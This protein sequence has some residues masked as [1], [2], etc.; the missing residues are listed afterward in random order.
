MKVLPEDQLQTYLLQ[1]GVNSKEDREFII[2]KTQ[3]LP[4]AVQILLKIYQNKGGRFDQQSETEGYT[5]LFRLYFSRH[6]GSLTQTLV[7]TLS[8]FD[9]WDMEIVQYIDKGNDCNTVFQELIQNAA[10]VEKS[11]SAN[12]REETTYRLVDIV[13]K[14]MQVLLSQEEN[15]GM[16]LD[17]NRRKYGYEK[18]KADALMDKWGK[19]QVGYEGY[20]TFG[21]RCREAF[22]AAVQ[23]Y[24]SQEDFEHIAGWCL[25]V[26]SFLEEKGFFELEAE[27]SDFFLGEVEKR[28]RFFYDTPGDE[29]RMFRFRTMTNRAWAY[30]NIGDREKAS[31]YAGECYTEVLRTM[32][33]GFPYTAFAF[34]R[35]GLTFRDGCDY[36]TA[37][38]LFQQ[39]L[40]IS[41]GDNRTVGALK[42]PLSSVVSNV[43]GCLMMDQKRYE[44]AEKALTDSRDQR[45]PEDR[46]G[47]RTA[48]SN[49]SKL[50]FRWAQDIGGKDPEDPRIREYLDKAQKEMALWETVSSANGVT[51][52]RRDESKEVTLKIAMDRLEGRTGVNAPDWLE[53]L[54]TLKKNVAALEAMHSKDT[55]PDIMAVRNNIAV[56]YALQENYGKAVE[57]LSLCMEQKKHFYGVGEKDSHM[58]EKPA[59]RDTRQN[60]HYAEFCAE[61]PR[62]IVDPYRFIL[63]Y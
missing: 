8:L 48:Y 29:R 53:E 24:S 58:E 1:R 45:N 27:L 17:A 57:L 19:K 22:H 23:C 37:E 33:I 51:V 47:L 62:R 43:L 36:K 10:L 31:A 34:Y 11:H 50:Y 2:K 60:L 28:D 20:M 32:G 13:R 42:S 61:N 63:L 59:V 21:A 39:C 35:Y 6:M 56:I 7:S 4:A 52:Y 26:E 3:G 14:T 55:L 12:G 38:W 25:K 40:S 41:E 54:N 18:Q 30:R 46:G 16:R 15:R 49:L 5:G 44:E 9:C